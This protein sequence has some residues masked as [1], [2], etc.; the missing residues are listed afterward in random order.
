MHQVFYKLSE[1]WGETQSDWLLPD[2]KKQK[3]WPR[4]A[5]LK[6]N[7]KDKVWLQNHNKNREWPRLQKLAKCKQE[8]LLKTKWM[9]RFCMQGM[10]G[11]VTNIH[12]NMIHQNILFIF[13]YLPH[14]YCSKMYSF[15]FNC[16]WYS[17]KFNIIVTDICSYKWYSF[18]FNII[19]TDIYSCKWYSSNFNI[20]V[21]DIYSCK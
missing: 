20:I 8:E 10:L 21:T 15:K 4:P 7:H 19:V 14:Y 5:T 18:N 3:V 12:T 6:D 17:F 13:Y 11:W 2:A 1:H 9:P 16:N